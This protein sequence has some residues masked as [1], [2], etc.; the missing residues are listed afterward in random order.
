M[1]GVIDFYIACA[2]GVTIVAVITLGEMPVTVFTVTVYVLG[3]FAYI[4]FRDKFF[5]N[6]SIGKKILRIHV[7][8][9]KKEA[10]TG[11]ISHILSLLGEDDAKQYVRIIEKINRIMGD[12]V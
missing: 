8:E 10:L 2:V 5:H 6:A 7:V 11:D 9:N 12:M 3:A 1:A 4:V